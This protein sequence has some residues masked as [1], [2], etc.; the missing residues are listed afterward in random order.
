MRSTLIPLV[1]S[2]GLVPFAGFAQPQRAAIASSDVLSQISMFNYQGKS[3]LELRPTPIVSTGGGDV[4][5]DYRDG[6]ARIDVKVK[7]L[8][9]PSKLG[10]Y[11]CYVLWALT[12]DGRAANQGVLGDVEGGK[13]K[14]D[15]QYSA[16]QF[17]LI[18]TAEPHFAVSAPSNMI[19]LY[20]VGGKVRGA[21]TKV[22]SLTEQSDYSHL[23]PI[24]VSKT[25][26]P[27]VVEAEYSIAIAA[28]AGADKYAATQY[29]GAQ[30]K[31][32][33]AETA[34]SASKSSDR[35]QAPALARAAVIAGEDARREAMTGKAAADA[36][37][38]QAAAAKLAAETASADAAIKAQ[39]A[40]RQDLLKRLNQA[41]PTRETDRG[42]VSEIGGVQFATG[43]ADLN[44]TAREG[45]ARLAGIVA[46]YPDLK[47]KIEGHTDNVGSD[48]TNS[49]LSLRRAISVRDY[50]IGQRVAASNIDAEGLG[51]AHPIADN[52]SADGRARNRRVEIVISGASLAAAAGH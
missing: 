35:K 17:A 40:A 9:P 43:T 10:P 3:S 37:A 49:V 16:S 12:P 21:E 28:A 8:P 23:T 39:A 22:R 36:A 5:V 13:A 42:L 30:Q 26:P 1:I 45:L 51:S 48:E 50:L 32:A 29:S 44:S 6:N 33:A 34:A 38:A 27:E 7:D 46:S 25:K 18:V 14:L 31:L 19:V 20:N 24:A 15:T 41:L 11:T 2:L 52:E 47:F 4:D